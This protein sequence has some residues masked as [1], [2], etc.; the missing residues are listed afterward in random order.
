M[1]T[2]N[3]STAFGK[4]SRRIHGEK[5]GRRGKP[6]NLRHRLGFEHLE[7]RSVPS[8]VP[9]VPNPNELVDTSFSAT[10][11]AQMLVGAGVEVSNATFTG[12]AA[13]SGS[14][15]FTDST[16]IGF[17]Q[18][19]VMSSGRA[20]DVVGPNL[21]DTTSEDF[22]RPGDADLD[23]LSGFT[24]FDAAVLEFDFTP[25]ANQVVFQYVFASDEYPEWVNTPYNDV[26]AFFV[27]GNNYATVRQYAGDPNSAFVPVA[28]NN[29]N[30]GN[31][32]WY[33]DFVPARPDLFRANYFNSAGPSVIDLE[34]DGITRVLTF[35]AP[36]NPGVT[37]HMK[38]AIAD[39]SDGIYDSAV[40]I[41]AGSLVSNEN[42]VADLS[43]SQESGAAPLP[44][45]AI[46]EGE[47]PNGLALTYTINWGD[48]TISTGDLDQPSNDSEKTALVNHTY[49]VGGDYIVTLT[50]SNGTLEGT[51]TEDL[52]VTGGGV[53]I[54]P[55][56]T[57]DPTDQSVFE[58][59]VFTFTAAATGSPTPSVQWQVST[60]AG[61][62]FVDIPGATALTYVGT[63]AFADNGNYYHA[64]FTNSEGIAVTNFALL[65]VTPLDTTPPDAPIVALVN[66]TGS[67]AFD[68]IT[69]SGA[70]SL[71]GLEADATVEYSIDQG[72]SWTPNFTAAE[73]VNDLLVRQTDLAGNISIATPFSFTLD[74]TAP[75]L[76]PTLSPASPF[77]VGAT[78]V[79]VLVNATDFWG[80]ASEDHGAINTLTAGAKNVTVSATDLAGNTASADVPYNVGYQVIN[81]KP[82][83][84]TTINAKKPITVSFQLADANG[85]LSDQAA[86]NL[87]ANI[88]VAFDSQPGV[89]VK[90]NK[91]TK[92]FTATLRPSNPVAGPHT[93]SIY[94]T[95]D[96]AKATELL[97]PIH[98]G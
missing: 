20:I 6:V 2:W 11:L 9:G 33:P 25:T 69:S 81:A 50:V 66:D 15:E 35:Q 78:G 53:A 10:Q 12:G 59:D 82:T 42:P 8:A 26:F 39:A 34:Q 97:I 4:L 73:G 27:N 13:S 47:D 18:G 75:T 88:K 31:P 96:G 61:F 16:V 63:A 65:S 85:L 72:A 14:F 76:A 62:T 86:A 56:V 19:I 3:W 1:S 91:K 32:E 38:L 71:N 24:T 28:V 68:G 5:R 70:I 44:I 79:T 89:S 74:T 52:H 29:I 46:I 93:V 58:G 80:I 41:Q 22:V 54:A 17:N 37:N 51:S 94:I 77:L 55:V 23:Q 48:G 40:F 98:I 7:D 21:S 49:T 95:V 67:S 64:V 90:Y 92:T 83:A 43:L 84:N 45:T 60:N 30:N 57:L 87:L 36:V